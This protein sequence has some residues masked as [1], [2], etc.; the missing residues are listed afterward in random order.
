MDASGRMLLSL[1]FAGTVTLVLFGGCSRSPAKLEAELRK[2]TTPDG[3][4]AVI[5]DLVTNE[6]EAGRDAVES[7]ASHD[8]FVAYDRGHGLLVMYLVGEG[9][10]RHESLEPP[11]FRTGNPEHDEDPGLQRAMADAVGHEW[12]QW[13]LEVEGPRRLEVFPH[14]RGVFFVLDAETMDPGY[15]LLARFSDGHLESWSL[16]DVT[17]AEL[18]ELRRKAA[19]EAAGESPAT[20]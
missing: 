20:R 8:P 12:S 18:E 3:L 16:C 4:S 5:R 10:L 1:A 6:G 9:V 14:E 15:G 2:A 13:E 19:G 11:R 7:F 17:R